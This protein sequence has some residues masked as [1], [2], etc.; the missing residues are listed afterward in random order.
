[1]IDDFD[2]GVANII[3]FIIVFFAAALLWPFVKKRP[4]LRL[5]FGVDLALEGSFIFAVLFRWGFGGIFSLFDIILKLVASI[6][7]T[8][9]VLF[10]YMKI[11]PRH[12]IFPQVGLIL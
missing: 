6:L 4:E 10:D 9:A 2:I 8:V 5:W 3:Q 11:Y 7:T 1:M 12:R